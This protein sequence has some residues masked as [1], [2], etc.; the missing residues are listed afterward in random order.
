MAELWKGSRAVAQFLV[1]PR[2]ADQGGIVTVSVGGEQVAV[3]WGDE[4]TLL[5]GDPLRQ[6]WR[7]RVFGPVLSLW[8]GTTALVVVDET[9]ATSLALADG[10]V[11][12]RW[13]APDLVVGWTVTSE[14]DVELRTC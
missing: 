3:V 10:S 14:A 8:W 6:V 5:T 13:D 2:E 7:V 4:I 9:G 11:V 1:S 12:R